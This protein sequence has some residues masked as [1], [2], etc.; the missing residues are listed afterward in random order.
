MRTFLQPKIKTL[1]TFQHTTEINE[2]LIF[3]SNSQCCLQ[4]LTKKATKTICV[5]NT[6]VLQAKFQNFQPRNKTLT[7]YGR[8]L[9]CKHNSVVIT[10]YITRYVC[11]C[12]TLIGKIK[13]N[14][15]NECI[16]CDKSYIIVQTI[17]FKIH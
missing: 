10:K 1:N 15:I 11:I 2:I 7:K 12:S 4:N 8:R 14:I 6:L 3:I 9:S 17:G 13:Y 16:V 5:N